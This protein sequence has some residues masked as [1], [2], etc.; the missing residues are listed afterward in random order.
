MG[1]LL[2]R[3]AQGEPCVRKERWLRRSGTAG[4]AAGESRTSTSGSTPE[5]RHRQSCARSAVTGPVPARSSSTLSSASS[6]GCAASSSVRVNVVAAY[7]YAADA[8]TLPVAS[9]VSTT[10]SFSGLSVTAAM[11]FQLHV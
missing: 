5:A 10:E 9:V 2:S 6:G 1:W 3:A 8:V 11:G 7:S 4:T